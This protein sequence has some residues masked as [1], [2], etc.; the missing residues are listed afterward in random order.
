ML[1]WFFLMYANNYQIPL[2]SKVLLE[3]EERECL[4]NFWWDEKLCW[5]SQD[6]PG[7]W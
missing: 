3:S 6:S 5:L 2:E 7:K 4:Q 1:W